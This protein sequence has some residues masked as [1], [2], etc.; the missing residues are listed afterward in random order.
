MK[1]YNKKL[2]SK[3]QKLISQL[4]INGY[5]INMKSTIGM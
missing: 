2:R 1:L 4:V 5:L 3:K